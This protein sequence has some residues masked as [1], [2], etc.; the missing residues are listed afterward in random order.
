MAPYTHA[1]SPPSVH[2]DRS[3]WRRL[4]WVYGDRRLGLT[5]LDRYIFREIFV[6]FATWLIFLTTLMMSVVLIDVVGEL[7]GKGISV[8]S[9][10]EYLGYLILE[11]L[12]ETVPIASLVSGIMAAGRLSGDSEITAM[13]SAGVSFPR[14]YAV[15]VGFGFLAMLVVGALNLYVGPWSARARENFEQELRTYHSLALVRPGRFLGRA[16]MGMSK[17]GQDIYAAGKDDAVLKDVQIREWFND[18]DLQ[19]SERVVLKKF[20]IPIGDGFLTQVLHARTGELVNRRAPDGSLQ[21]VIRLRNGFLIE[22][23]EKQTQYEVTNFIDGYMDYVIP[24]PAKALGRL[25]VKPSNYGFPELLTFLERLETGGNTV[26]LCAIHPDCESLGDVKLGESVT[27]SEDGRNLLKLPAQSAM[28][29]MLQSEIMWLGVNGPKRGE[30]GGPTD[31][32]IQAHVQLAMMLQ[33]FLKDTQK[34][35][36]KFE[37]EVHKRLATP[38]VCLLFFFVSFPLGLVVKR[39]G[40]GMSFAV[41]G[42]VFVIYYVS[43]LGGLAYALKGNIPAAM[44]AWFPDVVVAGVGIYIMSTRTDDFAPLRFI[45]AP[46]RALSA[47]FKRYLAPVVAPIAVRVAKSRP[48]R[49]VGALAAVVSASVRSGW[50][51]LW[52]LLEKARGRFARR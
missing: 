35:K 50:E 10:L 41:A 22:V 25:N 20:T 16:D 4:E 40:R 45:G 36:L 18:L 5:V 8:L 38:V 49:A 48:G 39:S 37:V 29:G 13:R 7:L 27:Q 19:K 1:N 11:K 30:P 14:I 47:R 21:K 44:G 6:P 34:T 51:W 42:L 46:F 12:T 2:S 24:P 23:D 26:D 3:L 28:E 32:E 9:I 31:Q 33:G 17:K 52:A 43:L 15:Y